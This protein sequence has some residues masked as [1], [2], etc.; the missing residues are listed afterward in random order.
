MYSF[1]HTERAVINHIE[2]GSFPERAQKASRQ[3]QSV[4]VWLGLGTPDPEEN[5]SQERR[6]RGKHQTCTRAKLLQLCPT[7]CD[8]V[9][10]SLPGSS[11]HGILQ[12]RIW[13]GL[14]FPSPGESFQPRDGNSISLGLLH[15]PG[16]FF[17][18]STTWEAQE[19]SECNTK[20]HHLAAS[21]PKGLSLS[22]TSTTVGV[23]RSA[24]P[25]S[26]SFIYPK[27]IKW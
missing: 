4:C 8:P 11:V 6:G 27:K 23:L 16:G 21:H 5:W 3:L 18:T 20:S 1:L 15:W 2:S 25:S 14:P 26:N 12:A 9:Y 19:A 10:Y 7:L 13:S 22:L 17:T 24:V